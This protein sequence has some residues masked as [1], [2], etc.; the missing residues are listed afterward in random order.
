VSAHT[1]GPWTVE[2]WNRDVVVNYQPVSVW[3]GGKQLRIAD[4]SAGD[5]DAALIAAAPDLLEALESC[6]TLFF[7]LPYTLNTPAY[8]AMDA[9][10]AKATQ[11]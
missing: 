5:A 8:A 2:K 6:R 10:I 7:A 9:A 1:P 11:P 3:I 4:S